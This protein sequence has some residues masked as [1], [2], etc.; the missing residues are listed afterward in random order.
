VIDDVTMAVGLSWNEGDDIYLLGYAEPSIE[1]SDYLEVVHGLKAGTPPAIDFEQ[2]RQLQQFLRALIATGT[3]SA[4][5]DISGG[6][7]AVA[8][9]EMACLSGFGAEV[10]VTTFDRRM[11]ARWFGECASRALV[12][13]SPAQRSSIEQVAHSSGVPVVRIGTVGGDS[14]SL[15]ASPPLSLS[16]MAASRSSGLRVASDVVGNVA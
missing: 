7:I 12:T 16:D 14:L 11:D 10:D 8:L 3:V 9:A 6:G 4:V 2:E 13:A 15:G 1:A 5:H